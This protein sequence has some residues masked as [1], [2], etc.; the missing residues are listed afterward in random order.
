[1]ADHFIREIEAALAPAKITVDE[2]IKEV[3]RELVMREQVYGKHQPM[4]SVNARRIVVM[5]AV[6]KTLEQ[7]APRLRAQKELL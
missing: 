5:E 7:I 6:L 2:M 1:M 4:P 3:R